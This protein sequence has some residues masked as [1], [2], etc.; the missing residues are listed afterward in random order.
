L[1]EF[2]LPD[3]FWPWVRSFD[4][5][6]ILSNLA[7]IR[8]TRLTS[9]V[10]EELRVPVVPFFHDD[11]P[12][13]MYAADR[14]VAIPRRMLMAELARCLRSSTVG[15]GNS[16]EMAGEYAAR[17]GLPFQAFMNC[18]DVGEYLPKGTVDDTLNFTYVG[19]LHLGRSAA[20]HD[21][22]M[23]IGT[24]CEAGAKARLI[25]Y[26]PTADIALLPDRLVNSKAVTIGGSVSGDA[27]QEA[28]RRADVLVHVESFDCAIRKYT[29][30]S[31]ST[32]LPLYMS[33]GRPI[34]AYG[35][36]EGASIRH[37]ARKNTGIVV[38]E[39][40]VKYL[41]PALVRLS[42]NAGLRDE[43][44]RAAWRQAKDL[45]AADQMRDRFGGVLT[46]AAR[47]GAYRS[48]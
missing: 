16:E 42:T 3:G 8:Q 6:V 21:I 38:S 47:A 27:M 39:K 2:E 26:A 7:S 31:F 5:Q 25:V 17:F 18:V 43:Y 23:A 35:P 37:V 12:G 22:A 30:L 32:K 11:W 20:L 1:A 41:V 45:Y 46:E 13:T 44:G 15:I 40:G 48:A 34:L 29:R 19:G 4:P 28:L 36:A 10:A 9:R 14:L 33:V 24:A